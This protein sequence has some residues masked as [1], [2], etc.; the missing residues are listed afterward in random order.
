MKRP[1]PTTTSQSFFDAAAAGRLS[2]PRC[3]GCGAWQSYPRPYCPVCLRDDVELVPVAGTGTVHA[4][5]VVH[6]AIMAAFTEQVPYVHALVDLDEGIRVVSMV[7]DCPPEAVRPRPPRCRRHRSPT[8]RNRRTEQ[9][10]RPVPT[11]STG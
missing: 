10:A 4:A 8:R 3:P 5:T 7:I 11:A 1:L 2:F 6:R 9:S